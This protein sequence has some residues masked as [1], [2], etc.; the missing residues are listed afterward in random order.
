MQLTQ[1]QRTAN[2]RE[3]G[4]LQ[5]VELSRVGVAIDTSPTQLNTTQR[6]VELST[7]VEL[8]RYKRGLTGA[9]NIKKNRHFMTKISLYLENDTR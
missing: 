4:Q 6:R 3:V 8:C 1:L 9:S 5:W 7:W 2:Q